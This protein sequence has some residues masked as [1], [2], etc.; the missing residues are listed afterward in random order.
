MSWHYQVRHH[1]DKGENLYQIVEVYGDY[2][3]KGFK[4]FA[5]TERA[6]TA[7]GTTKEELIRELKM[8]LADAKQYPVI[9]VEE[10]Q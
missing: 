3:P 4:Q 2:T 9:E 5:V 1:I 10:D 7:C 8:M 6:I